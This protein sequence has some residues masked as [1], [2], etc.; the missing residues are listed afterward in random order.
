GA[1][2]QLLAMCTGER[3][4]GETVAIDHEEWQRRM[5]AAA[6]EGERLIGIA[7]RDVH[8]TKTTLSFEDLESG[9]VFLGMVGF[10]DPPRP[11]VIGAI[12]DCRSAGIAVKMITGDHAATAR[13]IARQL[14]FEDPQVLRGVDLDQ[15]PDDELPAVVARTS[16]FA[17]T[18]PEHKL[19]IVR[20][21]QS[22]GAVV[23]MT[24]DG[25]N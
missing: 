2:E 19:R 21:L 16:V 14:G 10:V 9:L 13:A 11:E 1:P 18:S 23:A 15:I 20:A 24:G 25:V 4:G 22:T 6:A 12:A 17:R 5:D 3:R 8:G 7:A